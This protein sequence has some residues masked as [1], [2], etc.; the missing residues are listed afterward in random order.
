MQPLV[1]CV[2]NFSEGRKPERVRL[3]AEAIGLS[4]QE[5]E[6]IELAAPLHD[7]GKIGIP[8]GILLKPGRLDEAERR[9]MQKHPLIGYEILKAL[10]KRTPY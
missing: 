8:D 6:T 9:E 2:P 1:E 7:I 10:G 5:A 3:I 4:V